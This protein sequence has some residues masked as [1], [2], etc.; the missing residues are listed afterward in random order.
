MRAMISTS[1]LAAFSANN[2]PSGP[3]PSAPTQRPTVTDI[4][5]AVAG[6][7]QARANTQ[8][9]LQALPSSPPSQPPPRGSLLNLSV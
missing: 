2:I 4:P 6:V 3:R 8:T 1:S 5:G 7:Q 9:P